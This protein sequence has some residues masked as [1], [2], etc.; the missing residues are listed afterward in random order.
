MSSFLRNN[1]RVP[2]ILLGFIALAIVVGI[3]WQTNST[4]KDTKKEQPFDPKQNSAYNVRDRSD[5]EYISIIKKQYPYLSSGTLTIINKELV[6]PHW[7]IVTTHE[8]EAK[9]PFRYIFYDDY[10]DSNKI[11]ISAP[12]LDQ[13][14]LPQATKI[15]E[16]V[17]KQIEVGG[18]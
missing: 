12:G 5:S 11:V 18:L 13:P 17:I 15:P 6:Q 3:I 7:F 1:L 10:P 4:Q 14:D 8:G 9:T 16:D 2:F